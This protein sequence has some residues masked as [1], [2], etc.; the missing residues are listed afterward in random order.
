M[1][2]VCVGVGEAFDETTPN[3]AAFLTTGQGAARRALLLDCGF[4][5][6]FAL[7]RYADNPTDLDAIYL[8]HFHGDHFFGLPALLLRFWEEGRAKPLTIVGQAGLQRTVETLMDLAYP[9]FRKKWAFPVAYVEV[10]DGDAV[11]VAGF[12]LSVAAS[13]HSQTN[14]AARVACEG[15]SVFYSGD[16]RPTEATQAL[17]AGVDL[18]LHESFS[19]E[20]D[21][22]GHGTIPGSVAF[23]RRAGARRLGLVHVRRDIRRDR[24][25]EI[26]A[27][28]KT[29]TDIDAR[30]PEPGDVYEL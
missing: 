26:E 11:A 20:A 2:C 4:T 21:T 6:P 1:R 3:C 10:A 15:A 7:Y 18:V 23:C 8:T 25:P 5:A 16:G 30:L 22:P 14:L 29:V 17:A 12:Q 13:E 9:N 28:L 19:L 24:R 27:Y